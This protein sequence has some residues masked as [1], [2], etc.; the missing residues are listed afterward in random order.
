[1]LSFG[2]MGSLNDGILLIQNPSK[3]A[4]VVNE[5]SDWGGTFCSQ[6]VNDCAEGIEKSDSHKSLDVTSH[7]RGQT[8]NLHETQ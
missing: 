8:G 2:E 1:M 3:N 4:S 5:R 7:Q 6:I